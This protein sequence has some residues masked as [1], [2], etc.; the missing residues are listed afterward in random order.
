MQNFAVR[1]ILQMY[2]L[3]FGDILLKLCQAWMETA[4]VQTFL[5]VSTDNTVQDE[6]LSLSLSHHRLVLVLNLG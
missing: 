3:E 1:I 5:G 6:T 2:K 4:G